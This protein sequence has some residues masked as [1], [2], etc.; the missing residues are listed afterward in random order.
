MTYQH[1]EFQNR[2]RNV[3]RLRLYAQSVVFDQRSLSASLAEA[4]LS[5]I[6]WENEAK[7]SVEKMGR[8]EAER[9]TARHDAS[10]ARMDADAAGNARA[11]VES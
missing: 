1:Q 11:K 4:E 10:I 5:S 8:D 6:V 7:E 3:E 2:L 9:D